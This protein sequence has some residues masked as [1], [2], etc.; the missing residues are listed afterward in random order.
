MILVDYMCGF[1]ILRRNAGNFHQFKSNVHGTLQ[2]KSYREPE[3][4]EIISSMGVFL[5]QHSAISLL[6]FGLLE[7]N[8]HFAADGPTFVVLKVASCANTF[9]GHVQLY[10]KMILQFTV[11]HVQTGASNIDNGFSL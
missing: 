2:I 9:W 1:Y 5:R 7:G 8:I 4:L 6:V 11:F 10:C 3:K